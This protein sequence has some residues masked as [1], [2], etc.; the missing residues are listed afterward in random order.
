MDLDN[1]DFDRFPNFRQVE[2]LEAIVNPGD[3]LYIPMY[4]WHHVIN[5]ED[6]IAIN[7]WHKVILSD[8]QL[9]TWRFC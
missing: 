8:L 3:I 4:W 2:S 1:P 9:I 6:T 5:S 7:F